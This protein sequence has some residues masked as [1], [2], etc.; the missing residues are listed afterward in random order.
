MEPWYE[1]VVDE[2]AG[3]PLR[4]LSQVNETAHVLRGAPRF[5]TKQKEGRLLIV[6]NLFIRHVIVAAARRMPINSTTAMTG[7]PWLSTYVDGTFNVPF[8]E[9]PRS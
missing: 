5:T 3:T 2:L 7:P 6:K 8:D 1:F 9:W 4:V